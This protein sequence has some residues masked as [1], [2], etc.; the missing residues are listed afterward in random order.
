[1][2][3]SEDFVIENGVL[4]K[5]NGTDEMM[6]IPSGVKVIGKNLLDH[7]HKYVKCVI[8]PEGV[9]E[10]KESAFGGSKIEEI[11]LPSSLKK[12]GRHAFVACENLHFVSIPDGVTEIEDD[13]FS[14]SGIE[15]VILPDGLQSIGDRAF[16]CCRNL[17]K[18]NLPH[19]GTLKIGRQAFTSC[20]GLV[21][22]RGCLILQNRLFT[23]FNS[24]KNDLTV[25]LPNDLKGVED[26]AFSDSQKINI[27]MN[28]HCPNWKTSGTA[29]AYGCA[30]SI[31]EWNGSALYF[32]DDMEKIVAKVVLANAEE[33]SPK[34]NGA[35]LSIRQ[36][37]GV[38]DFSGYDAYWAN[39]AKKPNKIR[40]ALARIQYPYALSD[41]MREIYETYLQKQS[42]PVGQMLIDE[43]ELEMLSILCEKQ[44]FSKTAL[45]KLVDYANSKSNTAVTAILLTANHAA[46]SKPKEK[47]NKPKADAPIMWKKPKTGT[48]L[49]GRYL[50]KDTKVVFPLE[51]EGIPIDGIANTAGAVPENYK[52]ITEVIIPEGYTYIGSKAFAGCEKLETI[53]LP[54]SLQEIGSQAFADCKNLREIILRK[55]IALKGKNIFS[56]A[57]IGT[58]LMETEKKTK[59]PPHLFYECSIQ[60]LVVVGGPFKSNGNVFG[61][62]GATAGEGYYEQTEPDNFPKSVYINLDFATWDLKGTGGSN[63]KKIHVLAE[64]DESILGDET[65]KILVSN[66]KKN[67]GK[68]VANAQKTVQP[69][70]V[71]KI[72][73][74]NSI[75]TLYGFDCDMDY[76]IR[77]EIEHIGGTIENGV[78]EKINYLV[79]PDRDIVK[80]SVINKVIGFQKKGKPIAIIQLQECR[81]HMQLHN[82]AI[83]GIEG[84]RIAANYRLTIE[85]GKITIDSYIGND[86]NVTI[87]ESIGAYP[88]VF[89]REKAFSEFGYMKTAIRSVII[90]KSIAVLPKRIFEYCS[91]LET[92]TLPEGLLTIGEGAFAECKML[93]DIKIPESVTY[94]EEDA[95]MRCSSMERI[96]IPSSVEFIS[97]P[98]CGCDVLTEIIVDERNARYHSGNNCNA[99]IETATNTLVAGCKTTVI[100]S[101]V[102]KIGDGAFAGLDSIKEFVVPDGIIEIGNSAFSGCMEMRSISLPE[103]LVRIGSYGFYSCRLLR[104]VVLPS[105]AAQ[106]GH[107]VF[108]NCQNLSEITI[109]D[110][111]ESYDEYFLYNCSITKVYGSQHS[112]ASQIAKEWRAEYI[113]TK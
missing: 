3:N 34:Q 29:T 51:A 111:L 43:G 47:K 42:L 87:P 8:V 7:R 113:E 86:V 52:S 16:L 9:T 76:D 33:T 26:L 21:D 77:D 94:I 40:V 5:Y 82:E 66:A 65:A 96:F 102:T 58:V 69:I 23:Y 41:E 37:N 79:V 14:F 18:I 10:I 48:H 72:D 60:N 39:L 71:N 59:I 12:I 30:K 109:P 106:V 81:R 74:A 85:N 105:N 110:S 99:I 24:N 54:A 100:P 64:F 53:S 98:F 93:R 88:V 22:E 84:A 95:F 107:N 2:S 36:E 46:P 32:Y 104:K 91:K 68:V 45:P 63:T 78:S 97:A 25:I 20:N 73:F 38:F 80:N 1:M 57:K 15:E 90:P 70:T 103:S 27:Q 112:L 67:P 75:F 6:L 62:T 44:L 35:I 83:F 101:I 55:E 17:K 108:G 56:G 19:P 13:L 31:I 92:V 61:D 89:L 50:G 11:T 4:S 28:I 49:I